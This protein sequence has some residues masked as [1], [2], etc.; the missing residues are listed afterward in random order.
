MI[1]MQKSLKNPSVH[2]KTLHQKTSK[3]C[4]YQSQE[5]PVLIKLVTF[6]H[7]MSYI[8][9]YEFLDMLRKLFE[10]YFYFTDLTFI[11]FINH[12]DAIFPYF[13]I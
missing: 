3:H 2:Y 10:S 8:F 13:K 7:F 4:F 11:K 6:W 1:W 9:H 5:P 12:G